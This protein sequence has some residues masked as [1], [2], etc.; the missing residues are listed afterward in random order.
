MRQIAFMMA[1]LSAAAAVGQSSAEMSLCDL[2]PERVFDKGYVL[3]RGRIAFTMHGTAFMR[4]R[5]NSS[6]PGVAVMFP[7]R[8]GTPHVDFQ[9]EPKDLAQLEPYFRPEGGAAIACGVLVGQIFYKKNF[10]L[11]Q[12][13]GGRKGM[14]TD[15]GT[16]YSGD[17]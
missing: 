10:H 8:E 14:V 6:P 17:L 2:V 5:C 7:G 16:H 1:V 4:E 12:L 15:P 3:L 13:G 9:L 11:H